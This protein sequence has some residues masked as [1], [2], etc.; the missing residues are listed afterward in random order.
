MILI[1]LI[2]LLLKVLSSTSLLTTSYTSIK[3]C[4]N[5]FKQKELNELAMTF[6]NILTSISLIHHEI[7]DNSNWEGAVNEGLIDLSDYLKKVSLSNDINNDIFKKHMMQASCQIDVSCQITGCIVQ[8]SQAGDSIIEAG[9]SI[10][11]A[12]TSLKDTTHNDVSQH[13]VNTGESISI[14]GE[15]LLKG[16]LT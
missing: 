13:I 12:G 14:F 11:E 9:K 7:Y 1:L 16:E 5:Y 3:K 6:E 10:I 8:A 4:C 15:N 2:L